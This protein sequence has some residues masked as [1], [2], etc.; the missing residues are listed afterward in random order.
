MDFIKHLEEKIDR[1]QKRG[2]SS[3]SSYERI[4][5][6]RHQDRPR[7]LDFIKHCSSHF[8]EIHGDRTFGDDLAVV[9]GFA[10]I[11][12]KKFVIAGQEKGNCTN[13]RLKRN[14]GMVHPEG[15]RKALRLATLAEKFHLPLLFIVDTPGAF[16]GLAAEERGQGS[17]IAVNLRELFRIKTPI[18]VLI[19]G[20]GCS[21]GALGMGIGDSIGML[22]HAYF[23]VISPEGCASILW[24]DSKKSELA[25]EALKLHSE[26]MLAFEIIDEIIKE[27]KEGAHRHPTTA[28]KNSIRFITE[29]LN[30]LEK[31]SMD[32]LLN[33]RLEKFRKMGCALSPHKGLGITL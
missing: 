26:H 17:A 12:G 10:T 23:S 4:Q 27:G 28:Y 24:R 9:G 13:S 30:L 25:S 8:L 2:K 5:I 1:I 16:P 33:K 6:A 3:L 15:F 21:G 32:E 29:Q 19:I 14:F 18:I 22:E 7:A 11:E 20:E 31:L